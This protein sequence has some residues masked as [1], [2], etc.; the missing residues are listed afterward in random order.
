[1]NFEH[2]P[3]HRALAATQHI[4]RANAARFDLVRKDMTMKNLLSADLL[5]KSASNWKIL[6]VSGLKG[7]KVLHALSRMSVGL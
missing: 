4:D 5:T 3:Y 7:A 2:A 6:Y 1:M